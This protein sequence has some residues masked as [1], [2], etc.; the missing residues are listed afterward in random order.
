MA[1]TTDSVNNFLSAANNPSGTVHQVGENALSFYS[2]NLWI[3][4]AVS[5]ILSVALFAGIVYIIIKTGWL[6]TRVDRI[7]DVVLKADMP[8]KRAKDSW[9]KAQAH[10]FAGDDN[11]LKM[12][13]MEAD[14]ILGDAL[15]YA[16][17]RG[18]GLGERLKNVKKE[19]MPNID[20]VWQA[21]KLRNQIAH[22]SGFKIK[23]DLAE[24]ALGIYEKALQNLGALE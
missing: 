5:V 24:R 1:T 22:E 13:I 21:H 8:K 15:R 23:R 11:D 7:Q 6:S 12:A 3:F 14:K 10:F 2:S 4:E 16:G 20:D 9:K 18:T 17:I 19:Q